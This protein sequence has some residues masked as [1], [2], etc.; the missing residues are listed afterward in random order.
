M[1]IICFK[2]LKEFV[3]LHEEKFAGLKGFIGAF[4]SYFG[5]ESVIRI[6]GKMAGKSMKLQSRHLKS[7]STLTVIYHLL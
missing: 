6:L 3:K 1:R 4:Q 5:V 2:G 7:F